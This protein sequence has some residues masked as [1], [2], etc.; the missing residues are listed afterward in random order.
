MSAIGPKS[1]LEHERQRLHRCRV[2][3][4]NQQSGR[5]PRQPGQGYVMISYSPHFPLICSLP[6]VPRSK[7]HTPFKSSSPSSSV[8]E[9]SFF[10][11]R[12]VPQL[13]ASSASSNPTSKR[14]TSLLTVVI[15][16]TPTLS[17]VPRNSRPRASCSLARASPVVRKVLDTALPSCLVAL[18]THGPPS[19]KYSRL[20]LLRLMASPAVTGSVRLVPDTMSRWSTMVCH[21]FP[22]VFLTLRSNRRY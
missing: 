1:D 2:Q 13:T 18:P 14:A 6:K 3:P 19:K 20:L 11:S 21:S 16:I 5:F 4:H 10:S 9:R 15:L 12:P 8:L 22:S 7:A 17:A